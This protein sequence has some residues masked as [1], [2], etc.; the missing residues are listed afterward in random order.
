MLMFGS[1][2]EV[3]T[4]GWVN[5]RSL[6]ASCLVLFTTYCYSDEIMENGMGGTCS[7]S[8]ENEINSANC[9]RWI[10]GL[11]CE[12][13]TGRIGCEVLR[14][15]SWLEVWS[16]GGILWTCLINMRIPQELRL[17]ICGSAE[18]RNSTNPA[19]NMKFVCGSTT[20]QTCFFSVNILG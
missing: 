8:G 4:G 16:G 19:F 12:D 1:R 17:L 14:R 11:W 9:F 5:L 7:T 18:R 20:G 6:K 15:F 13:T 2:W 3:G 10:T